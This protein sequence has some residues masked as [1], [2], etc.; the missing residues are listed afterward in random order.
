MSVLALYVLGRP[1]LERDGSDVHVLRRKAMAPLVSI[2]MTG[3]EQGRAALT[4][5]LLP[6]GDQRQG[7]AD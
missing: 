2:A 4:L 6:E 7:R 1:C 5:L 3:L